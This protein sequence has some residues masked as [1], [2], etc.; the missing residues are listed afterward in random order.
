[1]VETVAAN[2]V[3]TRLLLLR[4]TCS[5]PLPSVPPG[6]SFRQRES[7]HR[8]P[9]APPLTGHGEPPGPG[10]TTRSVMTDPGDARTDAQLL[11]AIGDRDRGAFTTLYRR[12][13]PWL[14]I[15]LLRR[16][17]DSDVVDQA[18]Q[19]T[20]LAVWRKPSAYSARGDVAAW[21]WGIG[22]RRLIDQLRR[23]PGVAWSPVPPADAQVSAED[24]VLLGVRYGD[25]ANAIDRLSPELL[26]V[27]QATLLDGLTTREAARVLGIPAGTVK[28]R[29]SRARLEMREALT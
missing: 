19:D 14:T 18:V 17:H 2:T 6:V 4:M 24:E 29:M 7:V 28:S 21:L 27:V 15:R 3:A 5:C 8:R 10:G 20:F 13:A 22:I 26:A 9:F 16:C 1:M 11:V 25:L 23:R 12:H